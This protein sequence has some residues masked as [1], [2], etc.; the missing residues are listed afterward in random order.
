MAMHAC[1]CTLTTMVLYVGPYNVRATPLAERVAV[2]TDPTPKSRTLRSIR[3]QLQS[4]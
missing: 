1:L 2:F 3:I 4:T